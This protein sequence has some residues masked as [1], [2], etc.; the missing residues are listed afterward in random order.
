MRIQ[1]KGF[2]NYPK[3]GTI[4]VQMEHSVRKLMKILTM[5][6]TCSLVLVQDTY[7]ARFMRDGRTR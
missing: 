1:L 6:I 2:K 7:W 4:E 3:T 5:Y